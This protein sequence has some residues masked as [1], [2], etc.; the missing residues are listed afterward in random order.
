M[1]ND[2]GNQTLRV[3]PGDG[4]ATGGGLDAGTDKEQTNREASSGV[5]TKENSV[6][7]KT[8]AGGT[9]VDANTAETYGAGEPEN[10]DGNVRGTNA[11]KDSDAKTGMGLLNEETGTSSSGAS[12]T[13]EVTKE[14]GKD[15]EAQA[16]KNK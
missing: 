11:K 16:A 14:K 13:G 15:S 5:E 8:G 12:R 7:A 2:S 6:Q 3:K 4:A 10:F 9:S 1:A